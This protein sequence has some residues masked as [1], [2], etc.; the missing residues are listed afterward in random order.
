[1]NEEPEHKRLR[2]AA[3]AARIIRPSQLT[4]RERGGGVRTI[5]L[6][7]RAHGATTFINGI[8]IFDPDAAVSLHHHNCEESVVILEG[9]AIVEIDGHEFEVGPQDTTFLPAN[10]SHRFRNASNTQS[11]RILWT[12]AS[13]DANRTIVATGDT[14][15]IDAEHATSSVASEWSSSSATKR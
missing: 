1:M 14:R 15:R 6:V 5:P 10:V 13:V 12:Y 8:T 4:A 11:M 7:T 9:H 2:T 3:A